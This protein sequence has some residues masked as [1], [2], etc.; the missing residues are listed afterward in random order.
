[1]TS[2]EKH[3]RNGGDAAQ[4]LR[5]KQHGSGHKSVAVLST[6]AVADQH[7]VLNSLWQLLNVGIQPIEHGVAGARK[8]GCAV[9]I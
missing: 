4:A 9:S 1:M 2:L 6:A 5:R 7:N 8:S 3:Q